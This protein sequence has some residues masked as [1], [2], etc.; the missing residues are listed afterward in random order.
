MSHNRHYIVNAVHLTLNAEIWSFFLLAKVEAI[1]QS[2]KF[3]EQS[4]IVSG[5]E[6]HGY[7]R[8]NCIGC[9]ENEFILPLTRLHFSV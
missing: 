8:A 5:Q 1:D 4:V 2:R 3:L 7:E 9:H 6:K